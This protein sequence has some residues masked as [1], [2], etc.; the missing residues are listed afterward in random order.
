[1][2]ATQSSASP[3]GERERGINRVKATIKAKPFLK[4]LPPHAI[5][6]ARLAPQTGA[7]RRQTPKAAQSD[8]GT[9]GNVANFGLKP[10]KAERK[11]RS[12][13]Q[14]CRRHLPCPCVKTEFFCNLPTLT[15]RTKF[16]AAE[17]GRAPNPHHHIGGL[18]THGKKTRTQRSPCEAVLLAAGFAPCGC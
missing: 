13:T 17:S 4:G 10:T 2:N 8:C 12:E 11:K 5:P 15:A 6:G 9:F 14:G 16:S 3:L 18:V 7:Q 1:M